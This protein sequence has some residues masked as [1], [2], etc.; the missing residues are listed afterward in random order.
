MSYNPIF[1]SLSKTTEVFVSYKLNM[2]NVVWEAV[3]NS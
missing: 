3:K 2:I 1:P